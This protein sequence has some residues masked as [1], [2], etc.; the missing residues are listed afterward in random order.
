MNLK[1]SKPESDRDELDAPE[2]RAA[3]PRDL[4]LG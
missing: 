4:E 2:C 1:A 3:F